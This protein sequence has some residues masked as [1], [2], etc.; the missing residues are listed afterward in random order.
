MAIGKKT[1]V[2]SIFN[3]SKSQPNP[4]ARPLSPHLQVYRLPLTAI[5]SITHRI[6]GVILSL[7]LVFL[8]WELLQIVTDPLGYESTRTFLQSWLGR[9]FLWLWTL[10]LF[11]HFNH[12][13]R[14][15]L[16]DIGWG[17]ERDALNKHSLIELAVALILSIVVWLF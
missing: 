1:A 14:H 9:V 8:V 4:S 12:G 2:A 16:W 11:V 5:L 6:T 13:I 10:S 15:L 17:F 7:G 3:M